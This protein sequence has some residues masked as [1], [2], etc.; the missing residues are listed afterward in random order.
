MLMEIIDIRL[1]EFINIPN[2]FSWKLNKE[3]FTERTILM[4]LIAE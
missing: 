3:L 2:D 4:T 1:N